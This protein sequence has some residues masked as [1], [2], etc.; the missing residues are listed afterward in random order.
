M[1]PMA[2]RAGIPALS[3]IAAVDQR[4]LIG[5]R[6]RL[7]WRIPE[8]M[9]HFRQTTLGHTLIM[10]RKTF[11]SLPVALGGRPVIVMTRGSALLPSPGVAVAH[12]V[13][14]AVGMA[15]EGESFVAGGA[16]IYAAFLPL[17]RRLYLTRLEAAFEGDAYFPS[18]DWSEWRLAFERPGQARDGLRFTFS[19]YERTG[20]HTA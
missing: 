11:E 16:D 20:E 6:G 5:A 19:R 4:G 3:I 15:G 8:D 9:R 2:S 1:K 10:G 7:P 14:E 12:S 13:E 17:A 18:V